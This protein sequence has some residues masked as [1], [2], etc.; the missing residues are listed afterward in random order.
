MD[1]DKREQVERVLRRE[2]ARQGREREDPE[3]A[4]ATDRLSYSLGQR[5]LGDLSVG[6]G[7]RAPMPPGRREAH[8]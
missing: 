7:R 2:A 5:G 1:R 4:E 8:D 6:G 3:A